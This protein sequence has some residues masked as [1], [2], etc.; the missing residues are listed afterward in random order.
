MGRSFSKITP[1][2]TA[3]GKGATVEATAWNRW[4]GGYNSGQA[5]PSPQPQTLASDH[6]GKTVDRSGKCSGFSVLLNGKNKL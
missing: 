1:L 4:D 2:K 5:A 6:T 3:A